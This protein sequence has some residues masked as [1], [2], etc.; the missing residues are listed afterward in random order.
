VVAAIVLA[1][2]A[3]SCRSAPVHEYRLALPAVSDWVDC[4]LALL[5]GRNGEWDRFLWG[6]FAASVLKRNGQYL[7]YY[8]GSDGYHEGEHTV[9]NRAIGLATSAD[10][11]QFT[12]HP[13]NPIL[14]FSP[15]GNHEEGAVSS[16]PYVDAQNRVVMYY[17]ANTWAG[18]DQVNADARL[19]I[20]ED[21]LHFTDQGVV[22]D[23]TDRSV[24]GWGD[25][26]FPVL[27]FV[28]GE[29]RLLYYIPN[30]TPQRGQ[31]GVA[32]EDSTGA[33]RRTA[34]ARS[35][36]RAVTAWGSGSMARVGS[37]AYAIFLAYSRGPEAYMEVRTVSP[38]RPDQLSAPVQRYEWE[39]FAPMAVLLD[40]AEDR[41]LL[42]YRDATHQWYGVMVAP[43]A[44][45]SPAP[46]SQEAPCVPAGTTSEPPPGQ[47]ATG[48]G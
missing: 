48:G 2:L 4:G 11:V 22:L 10:G 8:Q 25:E 46:A 41:W 5:S 19:A 27:A 24:W 36:R 34:P 39:A 7:L 1:L 6:G 30:G 40:E 44:G 42:Y 43:V 20:S 14:T 33:R 23:R 17:G 29:R 45:R 18:A 15:F 35:G 21:G 32:W 12:K 13:G 31:L 28:H 16:A 3:S 37:G 47:R 38:D 9:T 26:L